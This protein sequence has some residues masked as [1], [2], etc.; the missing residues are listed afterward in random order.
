MRNS[1]DPRPISTT[2]FAGTAPESRSRSLL[3][4]ARTTLSY[5]RMAVRDNQTIVYHPL[6]Q[7][8][9]QYPQSAQ[10]VYYAPIH[11][12]PAIII[13]PP[14]VRSC[15]SIPSY[16]RTSKR[17]RTYQKHPTHSEDLEHRYT[18]NHP[19]RGRHQDLARRREITLPSIP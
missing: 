17:S 14:R 8:T 10:Y 16:S 4:N 6:P 15:D 19:P 7:S 12:S 11:R 5:P 1:P 18:T 3:S 13:P 2:Q 9:S